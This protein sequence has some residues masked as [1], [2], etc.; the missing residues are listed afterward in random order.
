M[1]PPKNAP[2]LT[3]APAKFGSSVPELGRFPI[4]D[5]FAGG[6]YKNDDYRILGSILG[7]PISTEATTSC[8]IGV[9]FLDPH[10]KRI[11][12]C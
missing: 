3:K 2:V 5:T 9:G 7:P 1:G 10:S 4:R 6:T 12:E 8:H 11:Y